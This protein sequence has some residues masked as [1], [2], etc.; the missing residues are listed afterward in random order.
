MS[1]RQFQIEAQIKIID[2]A[3]QLAKSILL[4]VPQ[5]KNTNQENNLHHQF[6]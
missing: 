4:Q 1:L 6:D 5:T 2:V 3:V